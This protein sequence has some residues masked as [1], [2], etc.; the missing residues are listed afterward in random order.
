MRVIFIVGGLLLSFGN[1]LAQQSP[2][3]D[4]A[5]HL[6]NLGD[7][8]NAL[9]FAKQT[10]IS[11]ESVK[12]RVSLCTAA[13]I[14]ADVYVEMLKM[15]SALI[16]YK[17]ARLEAKT[18]YG[19]LSAQYGIYL[20]NE[21]A[22]SRNL[23]RYQT[24]AKLLDSAGSILKKRNIPSDGIDSLDKKF[25]NTYLAH[26]AM[27]YITTGDLNKAEEFALEARDLSL[28]D[29]VDLHAHATALGRLS[30]VYQKMGFTV[31]L[32]S[33]QVEL[34]RIKTTIYT[35]Q[36]P[37]YAVAVGSMADM[38]QR[39]K[40]FQKADSLFRKALEIRKKYMGEN[41]A[42]NIPILNRLGVVNM[43]MEN[44]GEAEKKLSEAV[45]IIDAHGGEKFN[46]Y[47]YCMKNVAR[48]Y[49]LTGRKQEAELLYLKCLAIY[50][51]L[52]LEQ[53]SDRLIVLHDMAELL[54]TDDPVKAGG[55]L[56]KAME[57]EEKLLVEKLD[58]LS[59][60]ELL[61]YLKSYK[62]AADSPYRQLMI[63]TEK[64]I[65]EAAYNSRLLLSG[66][67]LQN[68][69]V[70]YRNMADSSNSLLGELWKD[71]VKLKSYH[72]SLLLTPQDQRKD[73]ADSIATLL[74]M[75]EKEILRKSADYRNMKQRLSIKWQDLQ[76]QL[77]KREVAIEFIRFNSVSKISNPARA[78]AYYYAAMLIRPGEDAPQFVRLSS[79]DQ[80]VA[81]LRK[82]PYKASVKTSGKS[83][84]QNS[85]SAANTIYRLLWQPLEKFLADSRT[86]YFSPDG[87]LHRVSFAAI[88]VADKVL[89]CDKYKLVQLTSTRQIAFQEHNTSDVSSMVMFGGID[90][91]HQSKH[92]TA[93]RPETTDY[94][95]DEV[96][97]MGVDSF[98]FLPHTLNEIK[99]I[100]TTAEVLRNKPVLY[101]AENA[102]E[103]A[104]RSLRGDASPTVI[105][106]ATH[107]FVIPLTSQLDSKPK[108][109]LKI[110]NN[111][112]LR[113]GLVMAGGNK[114]WKGEAGLHE[115]DG[116][117]TG[118]EIS[119][120]QL[121]NTRLAVL[122]A[123]ETGLGDIEGSEGVFGLQRAF[124]LAGVNYV[125]ASL[126][127][128]PDKETASFMKLFYSKLLNGKP[129]R[130]SFYDTQMQMRKMHP[131]YYWAGFT[132]VQ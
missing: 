121:P 93:V 21:G 97:G 86:V 18:I 14:I 5:L 67:S 34:Y 62:D 3:K 57:A 25:Y 6:I 73:N 16:Y 43:E 120:I 110:A 20:V 124:K 88:P 30:T 41:A 109:P 99:S 8:T 53:H 7:Y 29:P 104:F 125:I 32:D 115:D 127:Q 35:E 75:Q 101:T 40:D 69:K 12:D 59:E 74:N 98:L 71:H 27:F 87:L 116:L 117:L 85:L 50:D 122:S 52:G 91:T 4:S 51:N 9:T 95:F 68:S 96:R 81:A 130:E 33:V 47:A 54:Y 55:Y 94:D 79:E 108:A 102:T 82:F 39:C 24:A 77:H 48:L 66:V 31:K 46:L 58:F 112:L 13:G 126:W 129:I 103:S 17:K 2:F 72:T 113:C 23:G 61:T 1:L 45:K 56:L 15:D 105:H 118:L 44:F 78:A 131:P 84:K 38:Y 26:Y 80:L 70:L 90:Y 119:A 36:H 114:G 128:V 60:N 123:C 22:I 19:D 107:G 100:K 10:S 49:A 111:P 37:E 11:A 28:R 89:L 42:A 106:F 83:Q 92:L 65:C 63:K 132:L 76:R 64:E